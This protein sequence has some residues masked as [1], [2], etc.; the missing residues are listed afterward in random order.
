MTM[1]EDPRLKW[2][3]DDWNGIDRLRLPSE[4][5]GVIFALLFMY[6]CLDNM[7]MRIRLVQKCAFLRK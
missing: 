7:T 1:W 2:N 3:P 5:V 6:V 4:D